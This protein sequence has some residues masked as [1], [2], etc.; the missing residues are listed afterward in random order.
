MASEP[1]KR[2]SF[3]KPGIENH[4]YEEEDSGTCNPDSDSDEQAL[5]KK[6]RQ[7]SKSSL[8]TPRPPSSAKLESHRSSETLIRR[9]SSH[10]SMPSV[11][12]P[13][14]NGKGKLSQGMIL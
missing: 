8:K 9:A 1:T 14:C 12:C 11:A 4:S 10:A 13:T 3:A 7:P 5:V 6:E 2:L